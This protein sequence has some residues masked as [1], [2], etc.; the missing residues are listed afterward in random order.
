MRRKS[1][2]HAVILESRNAAAAGILMTLPFALMVF[3]SANKLPP[4]NGMLDQYLAAGGIM[5]VL[6]VGMIGVSLL[7]LPF[8]L[9]LNVLAVFRRRK[10]GSDVTGLT[11]NVF[12]AATLVLVI[13]GLI[14][15]FT[16]DQY[17]CWIGSP[18]CD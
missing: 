12:L 13:V 15:E 18:K 5:R 4:F 10:S 7:L 16:A 14:V 9:A 11:L 17:P 2:S 8:A 1:E 6:L 3:A